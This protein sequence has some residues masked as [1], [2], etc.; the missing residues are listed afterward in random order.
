[1][2]THT[3]QMPHE[4]EEA[5]KKEQ[6]LGLWMS[7]VHDL[8]ELSVL[9]DSKPSY[10]GTVLQG[11]GLIQGYFDLYTSTGNAMNV[12][13]KY[14]AGRLGFK[15]VPRAT[16]SVH[17]LSRVHDHF[18]RRKDRAGQHH[19]LVMGMTMFN[20]ARWTGKDAEADVFRQWLLDAL[21][22]KPAAPAA[23]QDTTDRAPL[24]RAA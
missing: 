17:L 3:N 22:D 1:M 6:I 18:A 2:E 7:G 16:R 24:R 21:A 15:D 13:S 20:R 4:H 9:T 12:Y 8:Q 5:T 14:F 23:E 19:A 10:V 11:E